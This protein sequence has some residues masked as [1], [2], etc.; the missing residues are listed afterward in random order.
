MSGDG[1]QVMHHVPITHLCILGER[2]SGTCFVQSLV[3]SNTRLKM[4]TSFGHKHFFQDV[5]K[6]FKEDTS[7]VLF[8][9]VTRDITSWLSSMCNTP[10]HA[11]LPIRNC[12]DVS[13]FIRMEWSCIHDST[14]GVSELDKTFGTEMMH[15]RDPYTGERFKN[16][17]HM[18]TSKIDHCMA[19]GKIVKNFVHVRYEDIR[20][21]PEEF[22]SDLASR[23]AL[24][25]NPK[26]VPITSMR[27]KGKAPYVRKEYPPLSEEDVVFIMENV[28][29]VTEASVGY[30]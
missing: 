30:V 2:V 23:F 7:H 26:F 11:D 14:S 19:I 5:D 4:D 6:L 17:I 16:V 13:K 8:V 3:T 20:E 22:V 10:Y 15:E 25:K 21:N 12:K 24:W 9:Y 27:G 1:V 18:R 28:D 29:M